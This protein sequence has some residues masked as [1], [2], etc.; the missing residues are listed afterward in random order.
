MASSSSLISFLRAPAIV[1][2]IKLL[3]SGQQVENHS[4]V[5]RLI[6]VT[7]Q[8]TKILPDIR[9]FSKVFCCQHFLNRERKPGSK[10]ILEMLVQYKGSL[11]K[12]S[13]LALRLFWN[14]EFKNLL[15]ST[16]MISRGIWKK[17]EATQQILQAFIQYL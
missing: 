16:P 10:A 2:Y 9:L 6:S 1:I 15:A 14:P 11:K 3:Y 17:M 5:E 4:F 8:K 12:M 13:N 7:G